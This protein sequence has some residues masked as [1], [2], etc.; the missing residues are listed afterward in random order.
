MRLRCDCG[1]RHAR[2]HL[3][4]RAICLDGDEAVHRRLHLGN[5]VEVVL[6][7]LLSAAPLACD[8]GLDG[9]DERCL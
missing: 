1:D 3:R 5:G 6:R 2:T 9:A 8:V 7:D 4:Q